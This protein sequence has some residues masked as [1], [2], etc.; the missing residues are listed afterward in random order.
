MGIKMIFYDHGIILS[1]YGR[2]KEKL[3]KFTC[4]GEEIDNDTTIVYQQFAEKYVINDVE[5]SKLVVRLYTAN[6]YCKCREYHRFYTSIPAEDQIFKIDRI[7]YKIANKTLKQEI[8]FEGDEDCYTYNFS[9]KYLDFELCPEGAL[10]CYDFLNERIEDKEGDL[11]ELA[12][13]L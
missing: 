3:G 5:H 7:L 6:V 9:G 11:G 10:I 1:D 13:L 12:S 8:I 2:E 4:G